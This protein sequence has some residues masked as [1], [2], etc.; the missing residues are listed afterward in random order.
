MLSQGL[1]EPLSTLQWPESG[2]EQIEWLWPGHATRWSYLGSVIA[3][4]CWL[5]EETP[6][7]SGGS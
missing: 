6:S 1:G 3:P 2:T 7:F 5:M 4:F